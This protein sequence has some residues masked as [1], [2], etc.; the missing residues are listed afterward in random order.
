MHAQDQLKWQTCPKM[1]EI[2]QYLTHWL[3]YSGSFM[4]RLKQHDI[5]ETHVTVLK[6]GWQYPAHDEKAYLNI[7]PR[8]YVL[9]REVLI[10]SQEKKWMYARTILPQHTLTGKQQCLARLKNRSLGSV[11]FKD[12][13][14]QRSDFEVACIYPDT[15]W[16]DYISRQTNSVTD[17][18]WARRS[19]FT[20][21]KKPLLLTEVFLP[22]MRCLALRPAAT[23]LHPATTTLRPADKPRDVGEDQA[24]GRRGRIVRSI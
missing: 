7:L 8:Q 24:A 3:L 22:D 14:M 11:I 2:P 23:T 21:Q 15:S 19:I 20:V 9:I 10:C 1:I 5:N 6:Q 12:P 17:P 4:Q 13:S 18:L 16:H